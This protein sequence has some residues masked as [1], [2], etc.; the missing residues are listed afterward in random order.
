MHQSLF[1][2][3]PGFPG[4]YPTGRTP[5]PKTPKDKEQETPFLTS[6][7]F[8]QEKKHPQPK[9]PS[10]IEMATGT[11]SGSASTSATIKPHTQTSDYQIPDSQDQSFEAALQED[12]AASINDEDGISDTAKKGNA[13]GGDPD[14]DNDPRGGGGP[15][16]RPLPRPRTLPGRPHKKL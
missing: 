3:T 12:A 6:K 16:R 11:A 15:G 13:P 2:L 10:Y 8:I 4:R 7:G 14:P 9:I 1:P 5:A